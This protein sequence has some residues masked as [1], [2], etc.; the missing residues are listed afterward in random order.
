MTTL[1]TGSRCWERATGSVRRRSDQRRRWDGR[2]ALAMRRPCSGDNVG[3]AAAGAEPQADS[4]SGRLASTGGV[5]LVSK[6]GRS[7]LTGGG[8][9]VAAGG[10]RE[11]GV[12]RRRLSGGGFGGMA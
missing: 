3:Q 7:A 5:C 12:G 2:R 1:G 11:S 4:E 10:G 6:P 8:C 9:W